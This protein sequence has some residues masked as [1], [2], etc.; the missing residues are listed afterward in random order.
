MLYFEIL[1]RHDQ[2]SKKGVCIQV[3]NSISVWLR[4]CVQSGFS[5]R[6]VPNYEKLHQDFFD[7]VGCSSELRIVLKTT[8]S[9]QQIL[10]TLWLCVSY[11]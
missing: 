6:D 8:C 5:G 2:S 9:C 1:P 7:T 10:D 11:M 3:R 4:S